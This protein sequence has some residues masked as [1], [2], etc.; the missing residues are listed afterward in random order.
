VVVLRRG[1]RGVVHE[2]IGAVAFAHKS[3][4][5]RAGRELGEGSIR[6][7]SPLHLTR[8]FH[9]PAK[10]P[11]SLWEKNIVSGSLFRRYERA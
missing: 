8:K 10:R 11:R 7:T 1:N 6:R 3:L 9:S 4:R 2:F 5:C